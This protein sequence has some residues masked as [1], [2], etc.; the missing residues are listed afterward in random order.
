MS[1]TQQEIKD[2]EQTWRQLH[3]VG[4]QIVHIDFHAWSRVCNSHHPIEQH[5]KVTDLLHRDKPELW[6]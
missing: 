5:V 4:K 6:T 1:Q 3:S 2:H